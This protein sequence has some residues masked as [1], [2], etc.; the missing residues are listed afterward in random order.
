MSGESQI[1]IVGVSVK[2]TLAGCWSEFARVLYTETQHSIGQ[3]YMCNTTDVDT[4]VRQA[5]EDAGASHTTKLSL[6]IAGALPGD[7]TASISRAGYAV[8]STALAPSL[9]AAL[10]Q[11]TSALRTGHADT[12]IVIA[13][14]D[15]SCGVI[16]LVRQDDLVAGESYCVVDSIC[17]SDDHQPR[18]LCQ[19]A[20]DRA[21]ITM[22]EIGYMEVTIPDIDDRILDAY[23]ASG[24]D[25]TC[26][27]GSIAGDFP[28]GEYGDAPA[29][30]SVS[31]FLKTLYVIYHRTLPAFPGWEVTGDRQRWQHTPFYTLQNAR[32]WFVEP[33]K[34]KRYA[35]W[36][37]VNPYYV[38]KVIM[39]E[40]SRSRTDERIQTHLGDKTTWLLPI[41]GHHQNQLHQRLLEIKEQLETGESLETIAVNLISQY[42]HHSPYAI[43]V[44]GRNKVEVASELT[45]AVKGIDEAFRTAK[46]YRTP[47]GSVFTPDPLGDVDVAY[48]YPGAFN[49]YV[50]FGRELLLNFPALHERLAV[51]IS[52][53]GRSLAERTLYPRSLECLT[54]EELHAWELRLARNPIAMIES[55]TTFAIAYTMIMRDIFHVR[56]KAAM[57]YSLGEISM[58]WSMGVWNTGD[59]G[60]DA[61]H[62]SP[63]FKTRLFGPKEAV[64]EAWGIQPDNDAF[65]STYLLKAPEDQVRRYVEHEPRV[66]LT[67]V[68][69]PDEVVIAGDG[70]G[71]KRVIQSLGCHALR[72]P[73]DSVIHNDVVRSEYDTFVKLYTHPICYRPNITFY[74]AAHY[75]PLTLEAESLAH[76]IADMTCKPVHLPKLVNALYEGGARVFIELGPQATCTRW[77]HRL[78]NDRPHVAVPINRIGLDDYHGIVN[79]LAQLIT[80]RVHVDL[81]PLMTSYHPTSQQRSVKTKKLPENALS[82][83]ISPPISEKQPAVVANFDK[84]HDVSR[85]MMKDF[86]PQDTYYKVTYPHQQGYVKNHGSF[87]QTRHRALQDTGQ[88]I[89]L[90]IALADKMLHTPE[91]ANR[92][93]KTMTV[94]QRPDKPVAE[95][96]SKSNHTGQPPLFSKTQLE[97]FATGNVQQ[98]FGEVYAAYRNRRLP[99]IPNS[100]LLMMSRVLEIN[101]IQGVFDNQPSLVSEYDV[102]ETAWY[103][104]DRLYTGLPPYGVIMEIALQPCGFLSA[105]LG[106]TLTRPQLDYYFRNLDGRSRFLSNHELRG[107]TIRS[108]VVLMSSISLRGIIMQ[109]YQYILDCDGAVFFNGEATFGYFVKEALAEQV[110]LD[111]GMSIIPPH[112][113]TESEVIELQVPPHDMR[114]SLDRCFF[115][116]R[117]G[118]YNKGYIYGETH[119]DPNVW[120]FKCHFFQDPVMPGSL[121]V[122]MFYQSLELTLCQFLENKETASDSC[123]HYLNNNISVA[124]DSD[125]ELTWAYRGQV[126]QGHHHLVIDVHISEINKAVNSVSV[127]AEASLWVD[128]LRIYEVKGLNMRLSVN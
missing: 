14:D 23:R 113:F 2:S 91:I 9:A 17:I 55:G 37:D 12:A 90:Q 45:L 78:L 80:N 75:A 4:L 121:G 5:L 49:S 81:H 29:D 95:Q 67:I 38:A 114:H 41:T 76:S 92:R 101:G 102:P 62:A 18:Q 109:R 69:L 107:K 93:V 74:S 39:S 68:N 40:A 52:N 126:N 63:L 3:K 28:L 22:G 27:W 42:E 43:A 56:A 112:H 15:L 35:A 120:F 128:G 58:L 64:R 46:P 83:H 96:T 16:I 118:R 87:L 117:G 44:V 94:A 36:V 119:V 48:V 127:L 106:S 71:C 59:A 88:L 122:D 25:L 116:P 99:R 98:C 66:Y 105:Y 97:A 65:W 104:T 26:A 21:G 20:F 125:Y 72:V 60:S 86:G 31:S 53:V 123:L 124:F 57:G 6:W 89:E 85:G 77:I 82:T 84:S 11:A 50:D 8:R 32:P 73:F 34:L 7:V 110:G 70:E 115:S 33:G 30:F 100:E 51:L 79:V 108:R 1:A 24:Y 10:N 47:R 54:E 103:F 19:Q 13:R 111:R 61:W